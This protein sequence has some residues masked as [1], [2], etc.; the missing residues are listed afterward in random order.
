[1]GAHTERRRIDPSAWSGSAPAIPD[2]ATHQ[3]S[4]LFVPKAFSTIEWALAAENEII[5]AERLGN[6]VHLSYQE[7]FRI[8]HRKY[9]LFSEGFYAL[10]D[11]AGDLYG[12]AIFHP[13]I[14][15]EPPRLN[16]YFDQIQRSTLSSAL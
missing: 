8:I 12:Y 16:Q 15:G 2:Q 11:A 1:V 13:W 6:K 5:L 9:E 7:D 14:Y 4:D 3:H 10:K